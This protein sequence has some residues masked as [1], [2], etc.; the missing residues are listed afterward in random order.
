MS[1][2]KMEEA[3]DVEALLEQRGQIYGDAVETHARI[4][5]VWS[6]ILNTPISAHEVALCMMGLKLVRADCDPKHAD[7]YA[8][9]LGYEAIARKTVEAGQF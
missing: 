4:A 3:V 5:Q 8:D 2:H 9:I 6:G 1:E 7:S